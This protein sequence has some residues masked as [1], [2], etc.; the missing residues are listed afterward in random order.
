MSTVQ[1]TA[2]VDMVAVAADASAANVE[3]PALVL[4][5]GAVGVEF[6]QPMLHSAT[7]VAITN[8]PVRLIFIPPDCSRRPRREAVVLSSRSKTCTV[9]RT[10]KKNDGL[11]WFVA[12]L[13]IAR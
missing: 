9:T 12:L 5:D 4:R 7:M 6:P 1:L 11:K 2:I 10:V 8:S 13:S 3:A